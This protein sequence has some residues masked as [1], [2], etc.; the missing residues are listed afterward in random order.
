M[1]AAAGTAAGKTLI[2]TALCAAL[3]RAEIVVQPYK[4]GPDYI[5]RRFYEHVCARPAYNV[6]LWLDGSAGVQA[7]VA[8]TCG[9]AGTLIFEGMMGLYDGDDGGLTSS[10][11]IAVLLDLEVII[12]LDLWNASQSAAAVAL[13]LARFDPR[14]RIAGAIL[15]RTG[16]PS[17]E[18]AVRRAFERTGIEVLAAIPNDPRY[19][20]AE[21]PLGL[22]TGAL[23]RRAQAVEH[24]AGQL[25]AQIDPARFA[26]AP[27]A[28]AARRAEPAPGPVIAYAHDEAFWFT[29]QET[30]DALRAAG[31]VVRPFSP[32]TDRALPPE[33]A[34][35]WIGGGY[36]E[37]YAAELAANAPMR[38]AVRAAVAGGLPT[39][40]EC[41][42][43]MY[44]AQR[45]ETA[46][47]SFAMAGA[48]AG[49]TS[50]RSPRLHI[51]YREA[52]PAVDTPLDPSGTHVRGYA[53]HYAEAALNAPA[54][55]Y[56]MSDGS[57]DGTGSATLCAAF[58]HR[59][60]LIGDPAIA[61]FVTACRSAR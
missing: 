22:D 11:E 24:V 14:V 43:L 44:L 50:V 59:H 12:V 5:D 38:D 2:S 31:A 54:P 42:G 16:G 10:A 52:A 4:V 33:S 58:L 49:T 1:V 13:G 15:N 21:R 41:G 29:Y 20:V 27:R 28:S 23:Q 25:L 39:Y 9:G 48:I 45:L 40:A 60:F 53:Y 26:A 18:R 57:S 36:P 47:G 61:R 32:L 8:A 6:D 35:L 3:R 37:T 34:G 17:H 51:G 46:A 30:L 7:N 56:L 19:E 55:A